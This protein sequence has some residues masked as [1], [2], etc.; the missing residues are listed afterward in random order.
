MP[1][2]G[3]WP[4]INSLDCRLQKPFDVKLMINQSCLAKPCVG[5]G[6]WLEAPEAKVLQ[7]TCLDKSLLLLGFYGARPQVAHNPDS[8][9]CRQHRP[10]H[11]QIE[12]WGRTPHGQAAGC[13][14]PSPPL[15]SSTMDQHTC[16]FSCH[17]LKETIHLHAGWLSCGLKG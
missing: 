8:F 3:Q 2:Y 17:S 10:C 14:G 15:A 6:H 13:K 12:R 5:S 16:I 9:L 7:R 4:C 11:S 1:A